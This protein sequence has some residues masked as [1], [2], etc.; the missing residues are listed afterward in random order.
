M[1]G[2][3]LCIAHFFIPLHGSYATTGPDGGIGRHE[4]LKIPWPLRLCGFK[5][6]S[7]YFQ[8]WKLQEFFGPEIF[9]GMCGVVGGD[10]KNNR[11]QL[12]EFNR[13]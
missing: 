4:G 13:G 11:R 2:T 9:L 1:R 12:G 8:G 7:G 10:N 5:S 6:H 3:W